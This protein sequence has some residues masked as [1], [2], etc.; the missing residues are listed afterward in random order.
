MKK[1]IKYA[2]C[3]FVSLIIFV[4][5]F[6]VINN[7]GQDKNIR[8]KIVVWSDEKTYD[9]MN[10]V[11]QEFMIQNTKCNIE[12]VK[13]NE[14]EL[15]SYLIEAIKT[16]SLP[17]I[18]EIGS[19]SLNKL[20]EEVDGNSSFKN[21][22]SYINNY[23]S[24]YTG[25]MLQEG[26][27][28]DKNIG[29]PFTTNPI[30]LYLREDMLNEYGYKGENINTWTDLINMGKDVFEKSGGKIRVLKATGKDYE[31]LIS[32]LVMQAM[33]ESN[34]ETEIKKIVDEK[35]SILKNDNILN[36][37]DYGSYLARLSSM[38]GMDELRKID[39]E[40]Q[41]TANNAPSVVNGG[42][43]FYLMEGKTLITFNKDGNNNNLLAEKFLGALTINS[44]NI[45][46]Y[47]DNQ[48]FLSSLSVYNNKQIEI[49]FNNFQGKSPLVIMSNIS[50]KAPELEEYSLYKKIKNEYIN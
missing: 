14:N 13:I 21:I 2:I 48:L 9:Y 33:E 23:S 18:V 19:D 6:L 35:I 39:T 50:K 42:N 27:I 5:F 26:K 49:S 22:D 17:N 1:K 20:I 38:E 30:V 40:C 11:A 12:V 43:R 32:L 16:G 25:R 46:K 37:D 15:D 47:L 36:Y 3:F 45:I 24:N 29:F 4:S 8:G 31:Y 28:D 34:S 10:S 41:W 44:E 7:N